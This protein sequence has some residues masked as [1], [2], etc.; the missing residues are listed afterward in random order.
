MTYLL[1]QMRKKEQ[2]EKELVL[3]KASLFALAE[4]PKQVAVPKQE[5]ETQTETIPQA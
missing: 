5:Q 2:V 4:A 1:E 3:T